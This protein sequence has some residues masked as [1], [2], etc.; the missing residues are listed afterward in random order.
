MENEISQNY[1][2][3]KA[4]ALGNGNESTKPSSSLQERMSKKYSFRRNKVTKILKDALKMAFAAA[5]EQATRRSRQERSSKRPS[6]PQ[7]IGPF[8]RELLLVQRLDCAIVSRRK[9]HFVQKYAI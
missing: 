3:P 7:N 5:R 9:N 8:Y 2:K 6:I 4:P 1:S